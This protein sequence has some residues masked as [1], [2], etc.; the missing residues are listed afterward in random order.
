MQLYKLPS[1]IAIA[2]IFMSCNGQNNSAQNP[3]QKDSIKAIEKTYTMNINAIK[4]QMDLQSH[5]EASDDGKSSIYNYSQQDLDVALPVIAVGLKDKGYKEPD[6]ADFNNKLKKIFGNTFNAENCKTK[7]RDKSITIFVGKKAGDYEEFDYTVDNIFISKEFRF[8]TRVPLVGDFVQLVDSNHYRIN[9]SSSL[10]SINK[11]LLNDSK[12]DLATLLQKDTLFLKTLVKS[13]GYTKDSKL[14][15]LAMNDYLRMDDNHIPTVGEIIFVKPC[16]GKLEIKE[17]LLSWIAEHTTANDNRIL[18]GLDWYA[19]SL[20]DNSSGVA[21]V[22]NPFQIFSLDE[23]RKI[24]A[25]IANTYLPLYHSLVPKNAGI[26]PAGTILENLFVKD[27][28]LKDYLIKNNYF[29]LPE[30]RKEIEPAK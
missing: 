17:E 29:S 6:E 15:D 26:W 8:I 5:M 28:G 24:V 10:V 27:D 20:Y 3:V 11:F 21:F 23:K 14:N 7:I 1:A 13:F 30:L 4:K 25:Y 9:L 22:N 19:S 2:S 18:E 16:K 12:A